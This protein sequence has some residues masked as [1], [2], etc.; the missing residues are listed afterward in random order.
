[1]IRFSIAAIA[2]IAVTVAGRAATAAPIQYGDFDGT[3]VMYLDV[4]E[5]SSTDPGLGLFGAPTISGDAL[6]FNPQAFAASSSGLDS[7]VT[8]SN[9]Q[10]MIKA[11]PGQGI[12]TVFFAEAGDTTLT[13]LAGEAETTVGTSV[14][15][16]IVEVDG[17]P[18]SFSVPAGT[19]TFTPKDDF[20]LSVDGSGTKVWNGSLF[21]DLGPF[22]AANG[23]KGAI[24]KI[25]V[26]LDNTLSAASVAGTSAFIQKKDADALVI[27]VETETIVPEPATI[28]SAL[29]GLGLLG[30][31]RRR[32]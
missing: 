27:T 14:F 22:A 20:L 32:V 28:V 21:L 23:I 7:D 29:I 4:Q 16:D 1:M 6:D 17:L 18:V 11:K 13:G 26:S 10:F 31:A 8:D 24:T 15:V 12:A 5:E 2:L 25:N 3:T 19:M 30:V 9:L